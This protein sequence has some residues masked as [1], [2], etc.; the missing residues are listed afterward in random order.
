MAH[1]RPVQPVR[2]ILGILARRAE[3]F[4]R[5]L[6]AVAERWGAPDMT[7]P[8]L[9]FD[10]TDYYT[11]RMGPDLKR[12]L[13]AFARPM[14]PADLA[15]V[16]LWTNALETRIAAEVEDAYPRPVNLDPGY[17]TDSKLVLATAK[18][19][20][21][22]LYLGRGIYA[23]VTLVFEDGAWRPQ[24]WTYADYRTPAYLD[25]FTEAR[26]RYLRERRTKCNER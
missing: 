16:K 22:R 7:S 18:D 23:E 13:C 12:R 20:S 11:P 17:L 6:E 8:D 1:P 10:F 3:V 9:D 19:G 24:P 2:P 5:A 4:E 21:H 15:E 14:D 25:F 26:R